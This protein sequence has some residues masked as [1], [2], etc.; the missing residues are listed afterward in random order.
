MLL[1]R[2]Q[3][4]F[5]QPARAVMYVIVVGW[6]AMMAFFRT[7]APTRVASIVI[8]APFA[9]AILFAFVAL[10]GI[11]MYGAASGF[12]GAF[13]SAGDARFLCGSRLSEMA[14]VTWLQLR[15]SAT[16]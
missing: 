12:V 7:H 3:T 16:V 15:R 1:H 8:P 2:I 4:A 11:I 10:L 5:R 6:F 9:S 13:S 14:V